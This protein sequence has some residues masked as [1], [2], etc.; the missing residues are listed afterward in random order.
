M[1]KRDRYAA[2]VGEINALAAVGA[3]LI[4]NSDPLLIYGG[5]SMDSINQDLARNRG[6]PRY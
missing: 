3:E 1:L 4:A 2:L 5:Y 6:R